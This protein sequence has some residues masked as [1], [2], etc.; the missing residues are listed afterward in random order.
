MDLVKLVPIAD[1]DI[2]GHYRKH[3]GD[4][5][6]L[7]DSI[8]R[9]GLLHP[10]VIAPDNRLIAGL[11]RYQACKDVLGWTEILCRVLDLDSILAG[12]YAENEVRKDFTPS[13]RVAIAKAI[14]AE[15]GNRSGRPS[16]QP[17]SQG[18]N[19]KSNGSNDKKKVAEK[20]PF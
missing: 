2:S 14:E 4:L 18:G 5:D 20:P 10:I 8:D 1:L 7:A 15:I 13:E 11:R 17:P 12:Q 9:L 19:R 6:K 16:T 3:M